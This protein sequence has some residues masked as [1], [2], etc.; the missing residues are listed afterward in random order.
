M[1]FEGG[2]GG[3]QSSSSW[4]WDDFV[5]RATVLDEA[6]GFLDRGAIRLRVTLE[7]VG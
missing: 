3:P 4:G 5:S 2:S 6:M 1:M 7:V